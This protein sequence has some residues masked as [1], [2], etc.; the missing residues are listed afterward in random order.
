MADNH[1]HWLWEPIRNIIEM[2]D[3]KRSKKGDNRVFTTFTMS[4]FIFREGR[5]L[6]LQPTD[7]P[8]WTVPSRSVRRL[9]NEGRGCEGLV[10]QMFYDAIRTKTLDHIQFID[11]AIPDATKSIAEISATELHMNVLL[12]VPEDLSLDGD[13]L[14]YLP[15]QWQDLQW[16]DHATAVSLEIENPKRERLRAA[17]H[18]YT[19]IANAHRR[20]AQGHDATQLY[21]T[22][23]NSCKLARELKNVWYGGARVDHI[24]VAVKT[25]EPEAGLFLI[26]KIDDILA[27]KFHDGTYTKVVVALGYEGGQYPEERMNLV[28][29][30][31]RGSGIL[32]Q[33][34]GL[35]LMLEEE[36]RLKISWRT[37]SRTLYFKGSD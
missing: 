29:E 31:Q 3:K 6:L 36:V 15:G 22:A 7:T 10:L 27:K 5:L 1:Y 9:D 26:W 32:R 2:H 23:Y 25:R 24:L 34:I 13:S 14:P 12:S 19:A 11:L 18:Q 4:V 16:A 30:F 8:G 21:A 35:H 17:F 37:W 33:N 28:G 20:F